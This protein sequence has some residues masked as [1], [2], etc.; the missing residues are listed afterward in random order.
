[1][2]NCRVV[3]HL[4][5]SEVARTGPSTLYNFKYFGNFLF[6]S[7]STYHSAR[8]LPRKAKKILCG[9]F[10]LALY[11]VMATTLS[12]M[13]RLTFEVILH[14]RFGFCR[15][16]FTSS[17]HLKLGRIHAFFYLVFRQQCL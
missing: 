7:S 10:F 12:D 3:F 2:C 1:M 16:S 8:Y 6:L 17:F 5:T 13:N 14:P 15:F 11:I 9:A 4:V